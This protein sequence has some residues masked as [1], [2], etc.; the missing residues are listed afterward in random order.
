MRNFVTQSVSKM[1]QHVFIR[2]KSK[3]DDIVWTATTTVAYEVVERE[4]EQMKHD[5]HPMTQWANAFNCM[6]AL[7]GLMKS[8]QLLIQGAT[9]VTNAILKKE[10]VLP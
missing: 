1:D 7:D 4:Q 5:T 8:I 3:G 10:G 9:A 6:H 2:V